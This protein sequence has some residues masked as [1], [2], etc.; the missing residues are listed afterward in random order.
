MP[1]EQ[2]QDACVNLCTG[3]ASNL[4]TMIDLTGVCD[5][6]AVGFAI[7][8][9]DSVSCQIDGIEFLAID[10]DTVMVRM[11]GKGHPAQEGASA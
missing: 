7:Q 10:D 5:Y 9:I 2:T 11:A 4:A 1:S 3:V 6:V 8:S